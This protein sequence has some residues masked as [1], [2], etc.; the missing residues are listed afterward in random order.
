MNNYVVNK[1]DNLQEMDNFL[2]IYSPP[3][4]N[5]EGNLKT[6]QDKR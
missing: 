1:F 4:L 2:K 6:P 5:Q 3:K